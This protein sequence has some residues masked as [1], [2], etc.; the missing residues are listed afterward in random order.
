MKKIVFKGKRV[1]VMGLGLQGQGL[2]AA[3]LASKQGAKVTVTDLKT[4]KEL[5]PSLKKLKGLPI[6]YVLGKHREE[7]FVKADLIIRNP[8][9]P[10]DS[11]YL[12]IAQANQVPIEMEISLFFQLCPA[13]RENIIGVTGTRGK[14]TTTIL[15]GKIL[16]EAGF[17]TAV[18]GNIPEKPALSLLG[19]IKP[20]TKAALELSSW[21]LE[22]L[23]PHKISPHIAV[24]TNIYPDH[25][26]RYQSMADYIAAKKLIFA[27]QKSGDY[28]I[29]NKDNLPT[30]RLEKLAKSKVV[31]FSSSELPGS[32]GS[33]IKLKGKHNLENLAAAVVVGRIMKIGSK[34]IQAAVKDFKGVP[35]RLEFVRKVDGVSFYNDT[36]ATIPEAT[37]AAL[38]I[39]NQPI[40]LIAGGADKNLDFSQLAQKIKDSTV[41]SIILLEGA[42]TVRLKKTLD[43]KLIL[44]TFN[45]F[46]KAILAARR[47]AKPGDVVLL[48]PACTS[49]GMF[50]NEFNRGEQ[51]R[52]VVNAF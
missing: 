28:L 37:M 24:I 12:Q 52:R 35:H 38:S 13:R 48:S 29:L 36:C 30:K 47:I 40:I 25:M 45:D 8:A 4:A 2:W 27:F 3:K 42:G 1:I 32:I 21:Q 34:T 17:D 31:Y 50:K 39:F 51:F 15:I 7:D 9:V 49:F 5:A 26:N 16:R 10:T 43:K 6:K 46:K 44:G 11:R 20:E 22:G 19:R 14:T 41:K 23:A 18:G 33:S